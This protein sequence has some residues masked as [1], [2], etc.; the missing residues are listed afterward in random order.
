MRS[1]RPGVGEPGPR[2]VIDGLALGSYAARPMDTE[3]LL[4]RHAESEWNASGRWQGHA[5]PRLSDRGAAQA[6]ALAEQLCGA[7]A[8]PFDRIESSDSRRALRTAGP[9]ASRAGLPLHTSPVYRELHIGNWAGLRREQ[10]AERDPEILE[11]FDREEPDARPPAGETRVEIRIRAR[12]AIEGLG[13]AHPGARIA[14]VTHLGFIRAL[15][16]GARPGN[17]EVLATSVAAVLA[18]CAPTGIEDADGSE[19]AAY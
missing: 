3:L 16:P 6:R 10:I 8:P 18:L 12:A 1:T 9:L 7:A 14:L 13:A 5:D 2:G 17:A 11:R 4:I 15:V 19:K